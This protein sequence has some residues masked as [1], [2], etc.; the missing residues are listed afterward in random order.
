MVEVKLTGDIARQLDAYQKHIQEEIIRPAA[1]AGA[2]VFYDEIKVRVPVGKP[3]K[4]KGKQINGG[5]L[6]ASIYQVFSKKESSD[7]KKVYHLSWNH[8]KAPHGHLIEFGT[9]R[10][11][12][13]PFIRPSYE[14]KKDA[15]IRAVLDELR[16]RLESYGGA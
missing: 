3:R 16:V 14:A 2:Q 13:Y 5:T 9:S 4:Y 1:Q 8:Q 7:I 15:A 10:A 6:K 12:A 11:P